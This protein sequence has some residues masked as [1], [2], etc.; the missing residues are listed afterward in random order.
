MTWN[1]RLYDPNVEDVRAYNVFNNAPFA[2]AVREL[3][4]TPEQPYD[5][6]TERVRQLAQWQFW[7]R[8]EYE[9][10]V[11][12]WPPDS[13]DVVV[14]RKIDVYQQLC[15]NWERF[16]EYVYDCYCTGEYLD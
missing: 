10:V 11:S 14:G 2:E 6:L 8:C 12:A 3:F 4:A 5:K 9:C 7:A 16:A 1:V 15:W 13:R